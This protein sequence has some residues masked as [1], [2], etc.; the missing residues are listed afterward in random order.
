MHAMHDKMY[1][2]LYESV[3][4]GIIKKYLK[5]SVKK[6]LV[7]LFLL[8]VYLHV[9]TICLWWEFDPLNSVSRYKYMENV[10]DKETVIFSLFM[11]KI[12]IFHTKTLVV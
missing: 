8:H 11:M 1:V 10:D 7:E 5:G 3:R 2:Y 12:I 4:D 6:N 9:P